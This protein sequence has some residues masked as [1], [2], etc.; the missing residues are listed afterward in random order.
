MATRVEVSRCVPNRTF[1]YAPKKYEMIVER[2]Q[3]RRTTFAYNLSEGVVS[4]DFDLCGGEF[5]AK[6]VI[7]SSEVGLLV[8]DNRGRVLVRRPGHDGM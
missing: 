7:G 2:R 4:Y 5:L 8:L 3:E 6:F 1:P